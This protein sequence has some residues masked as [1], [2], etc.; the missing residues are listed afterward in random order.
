MAVVTF[1]VPESNLGKVDFK[2]AAKGVGTLY[3]SKGGI[4]W[5]PHG[6]QPRKMTWKEFSKMVREAKG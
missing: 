1:T 4:D 5:R 2:I 3:V 6:A